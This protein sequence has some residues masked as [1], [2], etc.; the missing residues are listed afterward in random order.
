MKNIN[1]KDDQ[2][3]RKNFERLVEK[4][5]GKYIAVAAG[6]YVLGQTRQEVEEKITQKVKKILPSVLQ[7]PHK[8]SLVCAL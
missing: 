8:E 2:W 6:K 4:Y 5:P 3:I 7:I 1:Q